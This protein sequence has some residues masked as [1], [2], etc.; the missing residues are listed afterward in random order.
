MHEYHTSGRYN[1]AILLWEELASMAKADSED[2]RLAAKDFRAN[3]SAEIW[4]EL[5]MLTALCYAKIRRTND[6]QDLL[7]ELQSGTGLARD[8]DRVR[9]LYEADPAVDWINGFLAWADRN[10]VETVRLAER[11]IVKNKRS[12]SGKLT[13]L[14]LCEIRMYLAD[15]LCM[16]GKAERAERMF[17]EML[18]LRLFDMR[19]VDTRIFLLQFKCLM[20]LGRQDEA[21]ALG[22]E[23]LQ[24]SGSYQICDFYSMFQNLRPQRY[25]APATAENASISYIPN[26]TLSRPGRSTQ[27]KSKRAQWVFRKMEDRTA[28][29][30]I[31]ANDYGNHS[32]FANGVKHGTNYA[33]LKRKNCD[34]LRADDSPDIYI[35]SVTDIAKGQ[36][37]WR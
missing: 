27:A 21:Y 29:L 37:R 8:R 9:E 30:G 11:C 15:A 16:T 2:T 1:A 3:F 12:N 36:F 23:L 26:G 14:Q 20:T 17:D 34:L 32:R 25:R 7:W 35:H 24:Y 5:V 6:A 13:D 10:F 19:S 22:L 18:K 31:D 33:A 4:Y 28:F